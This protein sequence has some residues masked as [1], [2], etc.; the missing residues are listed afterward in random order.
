MSGL[1]ATIAGRYIV[2]CGSITPLQQ[3]DSKPS[4]GRSIRRRRLRVFEL[5]IVDIG[6][7]VG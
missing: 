5:Q 3:V 7:V 2:L 6:F 1:I 4:M